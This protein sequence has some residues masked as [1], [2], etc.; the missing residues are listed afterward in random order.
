MRVKIIFGQAGGDSKLLPLNILTLVRAR[1]K[2]PVL[3]TAQGL[4]PPSLTGPKGTDP[5]EEKW[6]RAKSF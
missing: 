5:K 1:P 3:L 4:M 2:L 6:K